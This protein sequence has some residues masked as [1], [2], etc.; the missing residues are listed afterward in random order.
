MFQDKNRV[1]APRVTP[2]GRGDAYTQNSSD[3]QCKFKNQ[4]QNNSIAHTQKNQVGK[5][6]TLSF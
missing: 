6:P 5:F 1:V 2:K 4:P 3:L